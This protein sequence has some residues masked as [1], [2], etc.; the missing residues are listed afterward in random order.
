VWLRCGKLISNSLSLLCSPTDLR[1]GGSEI[2]S[3]YEA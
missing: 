1:L 2:R 3:F